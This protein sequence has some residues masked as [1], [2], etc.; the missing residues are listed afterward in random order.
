MQF[1]DLKGCRKYIREYFNCKIDESEIECKSS[2]LCNHKFTPHSTIPI[3]SYNVEDMSLDHIKSIFI[4]FKNKN[5]NNN[6]INN[7]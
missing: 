3:I 7:M 1:T 2:I 5:I 6:K 4:F